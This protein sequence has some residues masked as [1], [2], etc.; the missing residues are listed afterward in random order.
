MFWRQ[1]GGVL[2]AFNCVSEVF[3]RQFGGILEAFNGNLEGF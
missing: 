3:C 1:F 2:E